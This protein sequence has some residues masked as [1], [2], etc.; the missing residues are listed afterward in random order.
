[1]SS[2]TT[3]LFLVV[4]IVSAGIAAYLLATFLRIPSALLLIIFGFIVGPQGFSIVR[5]ELFS[6][7]LIPLVG[8][9]VAILVFERAFQLNIE[10]IRQIRPATLRLVTFGALITL[11][12]TTLLVRAV[13][14]AR[15]D[16]ALLVGTILMATGP[17][18]IISFGDSLPSDVNVKAILEQ[19][20]LIN[21]VTVPIV[22]VMVFE[23]ITLSEATLT[24]FIEALLSRIG[25]GLIIGGIIALLLRR[26]FKSSDYPYR[27]AP[28]Y[29]RLILIAGAIVAHTSAV[30]I[31][32]KAGI[33]AAVTAGILVGNTDILYKEEFGDFEDEIT[34][35][36]LSF[37]F[38][39]FTSLISFN[40]MRLRGF[41]VLLFVIGCIVIIRPVAVFASTGAGQFSWRENGVLSF[42]A[43]RW[44]IPTSVATLFVL[45]L[46]RLS[47]ES[48]PI[49]AETVFGMVL[50]TLLIEGWLIPMLLSRLDTFA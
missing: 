14:R 8:A 12:G 6:G 49:L 30:L 29:T 25:I 2:H 15:W 10:Q 36:V 18:I 33:T 43:P 19:E 38:I 42:I 24:A 17:T 3:L 39:I 23:A 13:L 26:L 50:I 11:I 35:L 9:G 46:Q 16:T 37:I 27:D 34:L 7:T 41:Q 40:S 4:A 32:G 20:G 45:R 1:M 47:P 5:Q 28:Q 48:A 22:A 21:D 44:L 31:T